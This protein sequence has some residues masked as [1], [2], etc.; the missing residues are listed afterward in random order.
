MNGIDISVYQKNIDLSLVACDFVIVKATEGKTYQ[1]PCFFNH[2]EKAKSLG[3]LLG[4]YHFARPENNN[5]HEEVTNFLNSV[6]N[7]VGR[8]IPVLD[9]ESSA[10][11]NVQWAKAFLD[12]FH[13]ITG[14]RPMIYMSESVVNTYDWSSVAEL[15]PLWVARYRDHEPDYNYDMSKAGRAPE[16]KWWESYV[17]WQWTS[18]GRLDGYGANLDC[19][20]F[21]GDAELW[22]KLSKESTMPE[23]LYVEAL[24]GVNKYSKAKEGNY[25][26][27]IDGR[28]S[29][30]QVKEFACHDGTDEILIDGE[31]VRKLQDVRDKYGVTQISSA[32]RTPSYNKKIG[33]A[34]NSQHIYGKASDTICKSGSP[35]EVAMSAEAWGMGG[36]GLY[37]SFTHIDTRDG[38]ARWD[39]RSGREIGVK[40]FFKTIRFG[41]TGE[42]VRI[43]QRRLGIKDDGIFGAQTKKSVIEY[44]K[45]HSLDPDG[46]AGPL[47]WTELMK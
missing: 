38:K 41:S 6:K 25:F 7:Y 30:F 36:I 14:V 43:L 26:F 21:Y 37:T 4:F 1:D 44:Q 35:L 22:R 16:V 27:T 45:N 15:Y 23:Y 17:M 9:W 10:K 24:P 12:D 8:G 33:G 31:L 11:Y 34:A 40:T 28:V 3:K 42:Y 29:N 19:N 2:I 47:T 13:S 46:I 39:N 18:S 32:Y 20:K 5:P